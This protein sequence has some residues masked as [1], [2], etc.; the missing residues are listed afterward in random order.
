MPL[1]TAKKRDMPYFGFKFRARD[2]F[3]LFLL[4]MMHMGNW[5][6]RKKKNI[7]KQRTLVLMWCNQQGREGMNTA[8]KLGPHT[9]TDR[10]TCP[11]VGL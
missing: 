1:V 3:Q 5:D 6:I 8:S 11:G 7:G 10:G 2:V 9:Q 4:C